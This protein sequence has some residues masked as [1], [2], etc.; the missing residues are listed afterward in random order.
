MEE[1]WLDSS[2]IKLFAQVFFGAYL[3]DFH[4]SLQ[5]GLER[6]SP[7]PKPKSLLKG[8]SPSI[9]LGTASFGIVRGSET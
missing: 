4:R 5:L 6:T 1:D 3:D 7:T 9:V 2:F 8:E